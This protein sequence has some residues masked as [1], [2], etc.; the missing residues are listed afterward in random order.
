[1]QVRV[2][3]MAALFLSSLSFAQAQEDQQVFGEDFQAKKVMKYDKF[4][5]KLAKTG[6]VDGVVR[7]KVEAVCQ[8]KG[9]WMNIV[10]EDT[11]EATVV[12]FKDYGFFVPKDIAGRTVILKGHGYKEA[13]S[14]EELR[15]LAKDAGKDQAT[16]DAITQPE[17]TYM[18]LATGVILVDASE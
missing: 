2:I 18:F 17:E 11:N 7:G 6:S 1:M 4:V 16:I 15:H 10:S 13:T 12:R 8:M 5:K 9:C 14:V 3:M